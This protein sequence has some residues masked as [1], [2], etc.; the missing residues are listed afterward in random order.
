MIKDKILYLVLCVLVIFSG[1]DKTLHGIPPDFSED[2]EA[3]VKISLNTEHVTGM[4]L[5]DIHLFWFNQAEQLIR[6]DYYGSMQE[7]GMARIILPEG[8]Y[9]ILA[10]L[11]V[12]CDFTSPAIRAGLPAADISSVASWIKAQKDIYTDMLTGTLRHVLRNGVDLIYIDIEPGDKGVKATNVELL[13]TIPSPHLPDYL[14]TRT[15][16]IPV[17]RGVAEIYRKGSSELLLTKRAMLIATG[18]EDI[19]RFDLSLGEGEYDMNLW[20]D[21]TTDAITD[22]HYITTDLNIVK[23]LPR[24]SYVANT[25][26]R[27]AFAQRITLNVTDESATAAVTMYR[28]LAKY[29]LVTTDVV[30]YNELRIKEGWPALEDLKIK[31]SYDG[32]WPNAYSVP[33]AAPAGAEGGYSYVSS[34]SEQSDREATIGKDYVFVNGTESF[35]KL[36]ITFCDNDNEAISSIRGVKVNYRTGCLTTVRGN[37]LTAATGGGIHIDTEWSGEYEVEF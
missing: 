7:L 22:N 1:C 31:I 19:F 29:R 34:L 37:F 5:N 26:T 27:D 30:K 33:N 35:V 17:L 14:P 3:L 8:S 21:Y 12:G 2:I 9:T 11:N 4:P 10:V 28:P 24:E 13:L 16:G 23:T 15:T 6:H 36:N 20:V 18:Q 25:D 32:F